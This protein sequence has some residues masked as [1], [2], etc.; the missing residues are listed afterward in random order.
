[1]NLL[2]P[3]IN[4]SFFINF[5]IT[6]ASFPNPLEF[7]VN[8]YVLAALLCP[9]VGASARAQVAQN[10]GHPITGAYET[11]PLDTPVVQQAKAFIQN[12]LPNLL[13]G[14]V[15]EAYSQV[16]AGLNLK[17][18]IEATGEDG[19]STWQ[20]VAFRSLDQYWHLTSAHRI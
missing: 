8:K 4:L 20:F 19:P 18:I 1:M 5:R 13:L 3:F 6:E 10:P 12:Q 15:S 7:P 9:L 11:T 17:L 16:V 2:P 14:E